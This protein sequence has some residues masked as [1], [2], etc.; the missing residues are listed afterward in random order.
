[1]KRVTHAPPASAG[2]ASDRR[3]HTDCCSGADNA[4]PSECHGEQAQLEGAAATADALVLPPGPAPGEPLLGS[5]D[6][7]S[8]GIPFPALLDRLGAVAPTLVAE[9]LRARA[10]GSPVAADLGARL[11]LI[12]DA[13]FDMPS[14]ARVFV[15][16]ETARRAGW[17][18][19]AH[20]T[21]LDEAVADS[22]DQLRPLERLFRALSQPATYRA[23]LMAAREMANPERPTI[24]HSHA[25]AIVLQRLGYSAG[26]HSVRTAIARE[27]KA[28]G[29]EARVKPRCRQV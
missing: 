18:H 5:D 25:I 17:R 16:Y 9:Y 27:C 26:E 3:D 7:S 22:L 29:I 1:M 20:R 11:V 28:R 15:V 24:D 6:S 14:D 2:T 13:L 21:P 19:R 8:F 10:D 12:H 4:L 23:L